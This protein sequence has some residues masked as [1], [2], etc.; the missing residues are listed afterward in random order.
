ML[1]YAKLSCPVLS[2]P[3][4]SCPGLAGAILSFLSCPILPGELNLCQTTGREST[5]YPTM[6]KWGLQ[7]VSLMRLEESG[8]VAEEGPGD[9]LSREKVKGGKSTCQLKTNASEIQSNGLGIT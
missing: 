2:S 6:R 4:L 3:V 7:A 5:I 1:C 9:A 8:I